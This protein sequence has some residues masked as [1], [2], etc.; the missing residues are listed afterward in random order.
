MRLEIFTPEKKLYE[1]KINS[2]NVPGTKGAFAV[3][4]NH[5]PI[6]STLSKG[7]IKIINEHSKTEI[8]NIEGGIIEVKK[9][10]I[11]ILADL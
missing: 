5:A 1:G 2:I 6:I 7:Q 4:H 11:V 10:I 9:N 8:I 3:L